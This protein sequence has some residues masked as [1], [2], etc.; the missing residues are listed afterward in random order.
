MYSSNFN[1]DIG[2]FSV[3]SFMKKRQTI[4]ILILGYT[5]WLSLLLGD[6]VDDELFCLLLVKV[7]KKWKWKNRAQ[8]ALHG[9]WYKYVKFENKIK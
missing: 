4:W 9:D 3:I 1:Y 6:R 8:C 2:M 5:I 7:S